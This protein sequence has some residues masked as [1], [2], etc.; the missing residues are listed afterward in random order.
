ILPSA[1][2]GALAEK[3]AVEAVGNPHSSTKPPKR[4]NTSTGLHLDVQP[5]RSFLHELYSRVNERHGRVAE[6][7]AIAIALQDRSFTRSGVLKGVPE[8][9]RGSLPS[10]SCLQLTG[11]RSLF[12]KSAHKDPFNP[13]KS[14]HLSFPEMTLDYASGRRGSVSH[15]SSL[16]P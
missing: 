14:F 7:N 10:Q 12:H 4:P 9:W 16:L 13:I 5:S 2:Y 6:M 3:Q 15:P 8:G 1:K 11:F